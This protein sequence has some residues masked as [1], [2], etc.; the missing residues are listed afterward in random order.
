VTAQDDSEP[1]AEPPPPADESS[2]GPPTVGDPTWAELPQPVRDRI[3]RMAATALPGMNEADV[4]GALRPLRHFRPERIKGRAAQQI[5]MAL[6]TDRALQV[7]VVGWLEE[8][9]PDLLGDGPSPASDDVQRAAVAFLRQREDWQS[10]TRMALASVR[11][12]AVEDSVRSLEQRLRD[13]QAD[14]QRLQKQVDEERRRRRDEVD[15]AGEEIARLRSAVDREATGVQQQRRRSQE[16]VTALNERIAA[17]AAEVQGANSTI[18]RL[19]GRLA[20]MEEDRNAVKRDEKAARLATSSRVALLLSVLGEAARGLADEIDLPTGIPAPADL[21]LPGGSSSQPL[22]VSTG[23]A[24][25]TLLGAPRA[26]LIA[27]GYN[28]TK[29]RWPDATL[30]EQRNRLVTTLAALQSRTGAEVTVVFDGTV[31]QTGV[32]SSS[33][34]S[35]R[36][37]FSQNG[38]IA[39]QLIDEIVRNEPSG[40]V[41]LVASDDREVADRAAHAGA[42]AVTV[43]ALLEAC[44]T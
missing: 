17:L 36:V 9:R 6:A 14:A 2:H 24:V 23:Q 35:V 30:A 12:R 31:A 26:H 39:D 38:Q 5:E 8:E 33:T 22:R 10:Q 42:R 21:A 11:S 44:P 27:D 32:P 25:L 37:R 13:A 28:V 18:R 3:V 4:P 16:Q 34:P 41:L 20:D 29:S 19:Q 1:A 43:A 15:K 7:S 40:R